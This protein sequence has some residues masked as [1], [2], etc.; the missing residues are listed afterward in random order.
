MEPISTVAMPRQMSEA[1]VPGVS[2]GLRTARIDSIEEV[3][4][5]LDFVKKSAQYRQPFQTIWDEVRDNYMVVP[6]GSS[7]GGLDAILGPNRTGSTAVGGARLKDPETHQVI[8]TL[9]SQAL[10]LL[11]GPLDYLRATPIGA[12]DPEKARLVERL[13][14]AFLSAPGQYRTHYQLFKNAFMY[15]TSYV[16]IGWQTL[17]RPQMVRRPY[18]DPDTGLIVLDPDTGRP[19]QRV[20]SEEVIYRDEP[21]VTEIPIRR[22]YPDPSGTRIQH[23]MMGVAK[24]FQATRFKAEALR[25]AGTWNDVEAVNRALADLEKPG[26]VD[27]SPEDRKSVV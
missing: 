7:P 4:F 18:V 17:T 15:G 22:F 12:D 23:D 5:V 14:M 24:S 10:L 13:I 1:P 3:L 25:D 20:A 21:L 19:I 6:F 9:T 11:L 2:P 16:E 26:K 8:E 27:A